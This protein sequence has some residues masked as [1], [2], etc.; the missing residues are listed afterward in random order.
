MLLLSR[1]RDEFTVTFSTEDDRPRAVAFEYV[2]CECE[3]RSI[4]RR[5]RIAEDFIDE[6]LERLRVETIVSFVRAY[7]GIISIHWVPRTNE[8]F[9]VYDEEDGISC[10]KWQGTQKHLQFL[11]AGRVFK[12]KQEAES[13][14]VYELAKSQPKSAKAHC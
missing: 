10:V 13:A 8:T 6:A 7:P 9:Y 4:L 14:R 5:E 3:L 1:D 11:S 2:R 12:T